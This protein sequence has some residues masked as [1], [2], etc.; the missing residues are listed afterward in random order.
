MHGINQKRVRKLNSVEYTRGPVL[1]WMSREQRVHDNWALLFAQNLALS[2]NRPLRVTFCIVPQFLGATQR[3]YRF[4]INGL[5]QVEKKL[6]DLAI[7]L[8]VLMGSP[9]KEVPRF[10]SE[11]GIGC[12]VTDFDPLRIKEEWK[13]GVIGELK[14][15]IYEVDAHNIVPCWSAS[16]KQEYSAYTFRRKINPLL[17][18]F[19]TD[20]PIVQKQKSPLTEKTDN[21]WERIR[22]STRVDEAPEIDWIEPGEQEARRL[23]LS[24]IVD[25]LS[26]Y[27]TMRNKPEVDGQSNL[28]PYL[29]FG[30]LSAQRV[31]WS[32]IRDA[33]VPPDARKAFLE[34]LIVRRELSDNFCYYNQHYDSYEGFPDWAKK[35]LRDHRNDRR[36]YLYSLEE[37]ENAK[38]HDELWN[39][40][41][42][43]MM[44]R[45]KMHGYIR[46]YWAKKILEWTES[47][48]EALRTAIY[49]NDRYELDGRDPNGYE[50]I[51]WS[52]GGLHDRAWKEREVFGKVRYMSFRG[53][54]SKFNVSRYIEN[55]SRMT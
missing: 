45:G 48:E 55:V 15:P 6:L 28:S 51:A 44:V 52:I 10:I 1:Y 54:A 5:Q 40:A 11:S 8:R 25:K 18:E 21:S 2:Y 22:A 34:E 38:T 19:L 46:M 3:Q 37:F 17:D 31:A 49:L 24:F 53:C 35:S 39:A 12:L 36:T 20:Y 26:R 43:E 41:Q 16:P 47:P 9:E 42:R 7:P 27:E 32:V 50:G 4:M 29:H 14:I 30:Q 23:L 33:D 13:K